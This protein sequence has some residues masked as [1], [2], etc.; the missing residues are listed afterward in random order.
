MTMHSVS[1]IGEHLED[2]KSTALDLLASHDVYLY[3]VSGRFGSLGSYGR[4]VAEA[5][6]YLDS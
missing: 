5:H 4:N 2:Q 1:R 3:L 6:L